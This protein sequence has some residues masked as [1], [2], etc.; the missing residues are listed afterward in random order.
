MLLFQILKLIKLEKEVIKFLMLSKFCEKL[1][2]IF[3]CTFI[4]TI[5]NPKI[6]IITRNEKDID[7]K[8]YFKLLFIY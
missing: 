1:L 3:D 8:K 6:K 5:I 2:D 4:S 7:I